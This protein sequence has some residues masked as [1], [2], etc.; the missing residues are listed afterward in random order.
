MS[1]EEVERLT[2]A[3]A[4]TFAYTAEDSEQILFPALTMEMHVDSW[5]TQYNQLES[6]RKK[7]TRALLHGSVLSQYWRNKRIPRGLRIMKEPTLGRDD[8]EFCKKWCEILNRCS[9]DLM[10]LVI[11]SQNKKLVSVKQEITDLES[12][13]KAKYS[14]A[15]FKELLQKCDE[16]INTYKTETQQKKMEKYRR[17]TM[18]YRNDN[19][20]PW[21]R[22]NRGFGGR[23]RQS[24][25]RQRNT[26]SSASSGDWSTDTERSTDRRFLRSTMLV[27]GSSLAASED[28][29]RCGGERKRGRG[30][31][32]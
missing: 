31:R 20:Y 26:V 27:P 30:A 6:L 5:E 14:S 4:S 15:Q 16:Q 7:E 21:L 19:V 12:E 11:D 28:N 1:Y 3:R 29:V 24:R 10:L 32:K 17:D 22:E 23:S 9:L 18:D 2:D 25:Q 13:L 8:P